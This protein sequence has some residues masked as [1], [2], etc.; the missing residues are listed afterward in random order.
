MMAQEKISPR[1]RLG[2][3]KH[4]EGIYEIKAHAYIKKGKQIESCEGATIGF[5]RD[6]SHE[7]IYKKIRT[8]GMG[9]AVLILD[10]QQVIQFKDSTGKCNFY[11]RLEDDNKYNSEEADVSAMNAAINVNFKQ[12]NDS[13]RLLK[14]SIMCYD[15]AAKK[16]APGVKIALKCFVKR[17]L[18]LLPVGKELNYTDEDGNIEITFPNDIPGNK[19][20]NLTVIVK[21]DEDDNYGTVQ[22]E[23]VVKWGVPLLNPENPYDHRS[24]IGSSNNAPWFMVV[25]IS[26]ILIGIWGYL[27]YIVYGLFR[28]NKSGKGSTQLT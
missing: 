17:A 15:E 9:Q 22:F 18:C 28:I 26:S 1:L 19:D 4:M 27:C 13:V 21:L 16:M 11:A 12:E 6:A 3:T 10:S 20:G 14:A 8:D 2:F 25:V 7:K 5:Y 24:L 23:K